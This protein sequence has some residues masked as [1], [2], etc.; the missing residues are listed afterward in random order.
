MSDHDR[1][2]IK[3]DRESYERH[4]ERK[5][6]RG[7]TWAEYIDGQREQSESEREANAQVAAVSAEEMA[8]EVVRQLEV[9]PDVE[10]DVEE[11]DVSALAAALSKTLG[12]DLEMA[13]YRGAKD[14]VEE[15]V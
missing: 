11:L 4:R 13:A 6:E 5:R 2:Q 9:D 14:A 7:L 10:I 15:M 1:G 12:S 8:A 3:L